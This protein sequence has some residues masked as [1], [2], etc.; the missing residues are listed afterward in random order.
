MESYNFYTSPDTGSQRMGGFSVPPDSEPSVYA[1]ST[2]NYPGA[3]NNQHKDFP[4]AKS[5]LT[6]VTY[7]SHNECNYH[8]D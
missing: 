2:Y 5:S 8:K 6:F 3:S 4:R 7:I 1:S